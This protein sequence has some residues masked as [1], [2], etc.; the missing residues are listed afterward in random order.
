MSPYLSA[1]KNAAKAQ[2]DE[3]LRCI[4]C[5]V[6]A[7]N[8][9]MCPHCSNLFCYSCV[10][11]W[12]TEKKSQCPH[13]MGPL[14]VSQLVNCRL[15]S[16]L[17]SAIDEMSINKKE[18][19]KDLDS[20][21]THNLEFYYY[22]K[23]CEEPLCT[24]CAM[25]GK[26]HKGH[27]FQHISKVYENQVELIK[28]EAK[29]L[30]GRINT[31]VG[32]LTNVDQNIQSITE[33]KESKTSELSSLV[34]QMEQRLESEF[35]SKLLELLA[36]KSLVNEEMDELKMLENELEK[37]ITH[38]NKSKLFVRTK[39]W[40]RKLHKIADEPPL[41]NPPRTVSLTSEV[42]PNYTPGSFIIKQFSKIRNNGEQVIYSEPLFDYGLSWRLKIYP[43]GSGQAKGA[44]IS[45]FLEMVQVIL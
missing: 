14:R 7:S 21:P 32:K 34:E 15:M 30:K 23:D 36:Q 8:P 45:V 11:R 12:L 43:N 6:R 38:P 26:K 16:D 27:D 33:S 1:S 40:I 35:K 28:S 17:G 18:E 2:I 44:Y 37:D 9:Q 10:R 5:L 13:C 31:M 39:E 3:L 20:C 41:I 22:C 42:V 29:I 24:D 25:F 19:K 4:I